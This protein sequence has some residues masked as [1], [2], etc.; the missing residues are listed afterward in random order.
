MRERRHRWS[1]YSL[2]A[3]STLSLTTSY[4]Y[5]SSYVIIV[6]YILLYVNSLFIFNY[7]IVSLTI[8]YTILCPISY[9]LTVKFNLAATATQLYIK[10]HPCQV[11][12]LRNFTNVSLIIYL[13][14]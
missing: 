11:V 8:S 4:Y 5:Y 9:I 7:I 2:N 13:Y 10:K 14:R 3:C 1:L 12:T 6:S